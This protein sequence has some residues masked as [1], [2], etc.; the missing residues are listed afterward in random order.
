[1]DFN[2]DTMHGASRRC[3]GYSPPPIV[4]PAPLPK[5]AGTLTV[6][7]MA[8]KPSIRADLADADLI[9]PKGVSP[10]PLS[11]SEVDVAGAGQAAGVPA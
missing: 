9:V 6:P 11:S 4:V 3:R 1:M 10:F 5:A 8:D 7:P 2:D